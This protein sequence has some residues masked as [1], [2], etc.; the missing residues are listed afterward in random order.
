M[1]N[2]LKIWRME[3]RLSQYE[4]AQ[5]SGVPRWAIQLGEN[6]LREFSREERAAL[7]LALGVLVEHL[8]GGGECKSGVGHKASR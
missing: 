1:N 4:L 2:K 5:A 3:R 8:F 7:A 6:D